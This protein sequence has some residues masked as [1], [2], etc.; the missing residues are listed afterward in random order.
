[1]QHFTRSSPYRQPF[2]DI[3]PKKQ[4]LW[5][6]FFDLGSSWV[7]K[8]WSQNGHLPLLNYSPTLSIFFWTPPPPHYIQSCQQLLCVISNLLP[9][10]K[11]G[12]LWCMWSQTGVPSIRPVPLV[13]LCPEIQRASRQLPHMRLVARRLRGRM[14]WL[15][16]PDPSV[17]CLDRCFEVLGYGGGMFDVKGWR[18]SIFQSKRKNIYRKL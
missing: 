14:C 4:T 8:H 15:A 10:Q 18:L 9:R 12:I 7:A 13:S 16:P 2:K 1:M 5:I 6:L 11:S 17:S 3:V